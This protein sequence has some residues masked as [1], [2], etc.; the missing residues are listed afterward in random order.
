M[1]EQT[2]GRG[3]GGREDSPCPARCGRAA[4]HFPLGPGWA[5][6]PP[7]DVGVVVDKGQPLITGALG[8]HPVVLGLWERG[9][10]ERGSHV[11]KSKHSR[12]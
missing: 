2:G 9:L 10:R 3:R 4:R 11:G 12:P 7:L 8:R 1:W 5:S 6:K